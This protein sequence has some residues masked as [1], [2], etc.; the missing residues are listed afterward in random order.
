MTR[1]L[2]PVT[3]QIDGQ[4][5]RV[6]AGASVAAAL[7]IADR[8]GRGVARLSVTGQ[9]R[10]P[11]CGMGICHECRV[12]IDGARRLACQTVCADGMRV[13]TRA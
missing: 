2:A 10:A 6:P 4:A 11:F 9:Q 5:V 13:E 3:L 8:A 12:A 1:S 7:C